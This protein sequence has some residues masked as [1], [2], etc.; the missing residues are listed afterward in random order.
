M[1]RYSTLFLSILQ[2]SFVLANCWEPV[3]ASQLLVGNLLADSSL[4]V[5]FRTSSSE[6][7]MYHLI[8]N[9][10]ST[11]IQGPT[12]ANFKRVVINSKTINFF[13]KKNYF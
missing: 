3:S 10:W 1:I 13:P 5:G 4:T 11:Y 7:H 9:D 6:L 12:I 2:H 8:K